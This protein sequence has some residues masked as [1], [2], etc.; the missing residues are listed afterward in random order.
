MR[1]DRE[2]AP[3]KGRAAPG[4]RDVLCAVVLFCLALA[5]RL[6]AAFIVKSPIDPAT[7]EPA[8]GEVSE[9]LLHSPLGA[10]LLGMLEAVSGGRYLPLAV[11][12]ALIGAGG[13]ILIYFTARRL[14]NYR[15]GLAAGI[16]AAVYPGFI[17]YSLTLDTENLCVFFMAAISAVLVSGLEE[18]RKAALSGIST[19]LAVMLEPVFLLILPGLLAVSRR[20]L[21]FGAV[22]AAVL[23]PL[24]ISNSI[25]A[26]RPV[27]VYSTEKLG[28]VFGAERFASVSDAW[29]ICG[30]I[31]ENTAALW[32]KSWEDRKEPKRAGD[33]APF[34][35]QRKIFKDR[36][37]RTLT[38]PPPVAAGTRRNAGYLAAYSYL[39]V[40]VLGAVGLL[41]FYRKE[42][43]RFALPAI[44]F[45]ALLI[46]LALVDIN[47]RAFVEPLFIVYSAVL[48]DAVVTRRRGACGGSPGSR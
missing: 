48:I 12:Q 40:T 44:S 30:A 35:M 42:D 16:M 1:E 17:I 47:H 31:Y 8:G 10:F 23:V 25:E 43:R 11:A 2:K 28:G 18:D 20:K 5:A 26:R 9:G 34:S 24:T 22:L 36:R 33:G 6:T 29:D 14:R 15:T 41:R 46:L 3:G 37:G 7:L 13:A 38:K 19:G 45:M 27:P 39:V 32:M 21:A 4:R